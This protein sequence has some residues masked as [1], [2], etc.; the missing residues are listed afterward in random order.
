MRPIQ[1]KG[2]LS[3][4]A[5]AR[6][7]DARPRDISDALHKRQL[8]ER[9]AKFRGDRWMIRENRLGEIRDVLVSLGRLPAKTA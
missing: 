8:G 4:A 2:F 9:H 5:A 3:V 6:E 1:E 7:I